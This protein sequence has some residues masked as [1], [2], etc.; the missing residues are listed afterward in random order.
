MPKQ[1]NLVGWLLSAVAAAAGAV[2]ATLAASK[3][4]EESP[5]T[6]RNTGRTEAEFRAEVVRIAGSQ[7]GKSD[8]APYWRDAYGPVW[9]PGLAWCGVFALWVLR[10][11]GL[12]DAK[13]LPGKGFIFPLGLR[14]TYTPEPGDVAYFESQQHQAIV[15]AVNTDGTVDLVNGNGNGGRVTI[16]ERVAKTKVTNFYSIDPLISKVTQ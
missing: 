4:N 11:A 14:L 10:Q 16:S 9:T 13:W 2:W 7:F 5:T 15:V 3:N 12:T 8:P 1:Q 6:V